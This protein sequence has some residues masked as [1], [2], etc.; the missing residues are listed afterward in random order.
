MLKLK[1][2][3]SQITNLTDARYFAAKEVEW[4]SFNF[5]ENTDNYIEPMR[6]RAMFDWVE[7]PHIIGEFDGFDVEAVNF[8][9]E[10]WGLKAV[11]IGG[12]TEVFDVKSDYILKEIAINSATNLEILR[13]L[14][15][16]LKNIVA[17][18]QLNFELNN[19]SFSDLKRGKHPLSINAISSLCDEFK[20]ILN[21]DFQLV[22]L[23]EIMNLKPFGLSL[24]G[25]EEER[26]GV[27]SFDELDE[28]F[29]RLEIE[30]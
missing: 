20:I 4:L 24:K 28:I 9:A 29:D 11:Q 22:E 25:G 23:E 1:I 3:A 6:A 26:V 12:N 2:K 17:A 21:I 7:V 30:E 19:F 18:F 15:L 27:K 14:L 16:P 5:A 13:G 10:N 8:Y